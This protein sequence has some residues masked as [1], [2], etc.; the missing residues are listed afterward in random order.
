MASIN[1]QFK[2]EIITWTVNLLRYSETPR[3]KVLAM[4][5][6]L[7][8]E[9]IAELIKYDLVGA[10]R[11]ATKFARLAELMKSV[12]LT[13]KSS[14]SDIYKDM[15]EVLGEVA[16]LNSAFAVKMFNDVIGI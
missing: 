1:D 13:I 2:D 12:R 7:E 16:P 10:P 14:Y 5:K 11:D 15:N 8:N 9:L 6:D 4:L 3:R